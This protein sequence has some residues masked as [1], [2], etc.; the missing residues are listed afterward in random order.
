M[1]SIHTDAAVILNVGP[2]VSEHGQGDE[3]DLGRPEIG[4][5]Y[6]INRTQNDA[7]SSLSSL[8]GGITT[9]SKLRFG[10]LRDGSS[11]EGDVENSPVDA[12]FRE[13]ASDGVSEEKRSD[14]SSLTNEV[15]RKGVH[16]HSRFSPFSRLGKF[17]V[18]LEDVADNSFDVED[19]ASAQEIEVLEAESSLWYDS[20][21]TPT[22]HVPLPPSQVVH[23]LIEQESTK[24]PATRS[25][26]FDAPNQKMLADRA[27]LDELVQFPPPRSTKRASDVETVSTGWDGDFPA[28]LRRR[29]AVGS[30]RRWVVAFVLVLFALCIVA[31]V[32]AGMSTTQ[33]DSNGGTNGSYTQIEQPEDMKRAPV[34]IPANDTLGAGSADETFVPGEAESVMPPDFEASTSSSTVIASDTDAVIDPSLVEGP[35]STSQPPATPDAVESVAVSSVSPTTPA[36]TAQEPAKTDAPPEP[37]ETVTASSEQAPATNAPEVASATPPPPVTTTTTT[38]ETTT[39]PPPTTEE[40]TTKPPPT[41]AA[42]GIS[43]D[44]IVDTSIVSNE[45]GL[46]FDSNSYLTVKGLR[47]ASS[48]LLFDTSDVARNNVEKA[49]LRIYSILP[50][51]DDGNGEAGGMSSVNVELLPSAGRWV[52]PSVTYTNPVPSSAAYGVGSFSVE[53]YPYQRTAI[54]NRLQRIHEVDVTR[55]FRYPV[56]PKYP[57]SLSFRLYSDDISSGRVDFASREW[58]NGF[59]QPELVIELS[60]TE[61]ETIEPPPTAPSTTSTTTTSTTTTTQPPPPETTTS[62]PPE[63]STTTIP[64]Q[65]T[66]TTPSINSICQ[67]RCEVEAQEKFAKELKFDSIAGYVESCMLEPCTLDAKKCERKCK[68]DAEE[69]ALKASNKANDHKAKCLPECLLAAND[70]AAEQSFRLFDSEKTK[71]SKKM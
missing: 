33:D 32:V 48:F 56:D 28:Y 54:F 60:D 24:T 52:G 42:T 26:A 27:H 51:S 43:L 64:P 25:V 46:S 7:E 63:P 14:V 40:P 61:F 1:S 22:K 29:F 45:P 49:V 23:T 69:K 68:R 34:D 38:K 9:L 31:I 55:A 19:N 2:S 53:G 8:S 59:A 35:S 58:N 39:K 3:E 65:T 36:E 6:Y 10:A 41:I 57:N 20:T 17:S 21:D 11:A 70:P 16:G 13:N 66:S 71:G 30:R 4:K 18:Q 50:S 47:R 44:T 62:P 12:I 37:V 67:A 15:T 5:A